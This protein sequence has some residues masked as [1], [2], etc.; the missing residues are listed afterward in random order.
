M[1][2][3]AIEQLKSWKNKKRRKPLLIQG[4]RQVGKT[5]LMK[6]F[7]KKYF[8]KTVYLNFDARKDELAPLFESDITP[9]HIIKAIE[10]LEQTKIDESTLIIF[11]EVQEVPRA[12]TALKYFCEDAPEYA[13][14]TAGSLLGIALHQGTSFPVGKVDMITLYPMSFEEFLIATGKKDYCDLLN[15]LDFSIITPMRSHF[16]EALRTYYFVGGMPEAVEAYA[17]GDSFHDVRRIQ[18]NIKDAYEMDY[19]KHAPT[20]IIPRIREVWTSI[21]S[22]LAKENKKFIYG[23]IR[24]GARA[25]DYELAIMWL[26]DCGLINRVSRITAPRI[27]LN[28]C[29]D[30]KAFKL[31]LDDVGLLGCLS[32]LSE[33]T[34]IEG[35]SMFTEFKGALTEQYVCQE[36][37]QS[38]IKPYY[39]TNDRNTLEIDFVIDDDIS[40]I[41]I[42]VKAEENLKAKSLKTF[43]E[44]YNL[45]L[46]IR[47]SMA[48][49]REEPGLI[50]VPLYAAEQ[51][52]KI[53]RSYY[54]K[55][56]KAG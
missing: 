46:S 9:E 34:L 37:V 54:G 28:S 56:C 22:Q 40:P 23:N 17:E 33:K 14:V 45:P 27:P 7:G 29:E 52:E 13:I 35:N 24:K 42:E 32:N 4:A 55:D 18:Q 3:K 47:I 38:G 50:N 25:K 6:E 26:K 48:D 41:P 5:W 20:N 11:D 31:Y 19:S 12:L 2:R 39:F 53:I 30:S 43:R 51:M 8:K 1:Y 44:K 15:E 10:I 16:I 36:L 21:P 49:Y